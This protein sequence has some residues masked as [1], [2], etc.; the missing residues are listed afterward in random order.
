MVSLVYT[1]SP[2]FLSKIIMYLTRGKAS[3]AMLEFTL[4]TFNDKWILEAT[5]EGVRLVPSTCALAKKT[6]VGKFDCMFDSEPGLRAIEKYIGAF[7]DFEGIVFLGFALMLWR[8]FK[9]KVRVPHRSTNNQICSELVVHFLQASPGPDFSSY[10]P[11][12][13]SPND[14]LVANQLDPQHFRVSEIV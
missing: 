14:L 9:K 8:W 2:M 5:V 1:K 11:M 4:P 7:Y 12:S 3:H 6:V 13:T 10:D